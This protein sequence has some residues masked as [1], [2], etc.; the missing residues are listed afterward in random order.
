V[1]GGVARRVVVASGLLMLLVGAAF[2][3]LIFSVAD[4]RK[5][6]RLARH[7]QEVLTAAN[8]LERLVVDL[9]TGQRGFVITGQEEFL[10]PWEDAMAAL[11]E[12]ASTL[13]RLVAD[14]PT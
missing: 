12:Q 9:E 3:V 7:S 1:R 2:A 8:Q 11:P 14:N 6:E 5:S 10:E 4:L 13:E